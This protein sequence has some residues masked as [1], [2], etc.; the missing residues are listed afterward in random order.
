MILTGAI[1]TTTAHALD[2]L[3]MPGHKDN[4]FYTDVNP[5][6]MGLGETLSTSV[7]FLFERKNRT[8]KV[9]LPVQQTDLT[10]F[11]RREKG[12]FNSTWLGHSSLMINEECIQIYHYRFVTAL[13]QILPYLLL[14]INA[15]LWVL[16]GAFSAS[17]I[18]FFL[19]VNVLQ[20][21][22]YILNR[23]Q[24]IYKYL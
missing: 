2:T 4:K 5:L 14:K 6:T 7:K 3:P 19:L 23:I 1:M 10:P 18:L 16:A 8:P 21:Y 17:Y 12:E 20:R 22:K 24:I 11:S 15:P 13:P 9:R